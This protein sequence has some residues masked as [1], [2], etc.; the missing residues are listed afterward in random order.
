MSLLVPILTILAPS[1]FLFVFRP[2]RIGRRGRNAV[3]GI[4]TAKTTRSESAWRTGHDAAWPFV[5]WSSIA[6]IVILVVVVVLASSIEGEARGA[7]SSLGSAGGVLVW[8]AGLLGGV[9]SA[10]H[11]IDQKSADE[12]PGG[13][14]TSRRA[15]D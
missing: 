7:V 3:L 14:T 9:R 1:A 4:R 12:S 2:D 8:L 10:H 11:A 5:K 15:H 13:S 6:F